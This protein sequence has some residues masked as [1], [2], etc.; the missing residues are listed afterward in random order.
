VKRIVIAAIVVALLI[1]AVL[2]LRQRRESSEREAR[3]EARFLQFDDRQIS[4]FVLTTNG[5]EWRLE[6]RGDE[7]RLVSPVSDAADRD[8]VMGFLADLRLTPVGRVIEDP[9]SLDA[10]GLDPAISSVALEGVDLPVAH[11]GEATPTGDGVF[12]RL[13]DRPEVIVLEPTLVEAFVET[14]RNPIRYRDPSLLDLLRSDVVGI[15]LAA[16]AGG[17]KL[18]READGWWILEP[19]RIPA[20]DAQVQRLLQGLEG[21]R[22]VAYADGG[23]PSAAEFGLGAGAIRMEVRTGDAVRVLTLGTDVEGTGARF[24]GRDDR[25]TVLAV[26]AGPLRSLPLGLDDLV[27]RR[28]TR[29]NRYQVARFEYGLGGDRLQGDREGE[30]W[31]VGGAQTEPE[32]VYGFLVRILEMPVAAWRESRS[33]GRPIGWL[34]Y[35]LESGATGRID[36]LPGDEA[37]VSWLPGLNFRLEEEPPPVPEF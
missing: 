31:T 6:S 25:D 4:G 34:E 29:V 20:S 9:E 18:A 11:F 7:W 17:V 23:D 19:R 16:P 32:L 22:V 27:A 3:A 28:L 14:V 21:A 2:V 10:Y 1:G 5:T 36:F 12:A 15:D 37:R 35:E 13:G 30:Q 26:D 24:A 33:S 8:A